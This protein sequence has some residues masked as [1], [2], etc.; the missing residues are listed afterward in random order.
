MMDTD[1]SAWMDG[2][3]QM[4]VVELLQQLQ[5]ASFIVIV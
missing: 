3:R 4:L 2:Y 5:P 1:R